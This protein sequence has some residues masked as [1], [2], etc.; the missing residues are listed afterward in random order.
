V[1]EWE[2]KHTRVRAG[3]PAMRL[4][5]ARGAARAARR[6]RL[7]RTGAAPPPAAAP[8]LLHARSRVPLRRA[9]P[10]HSVRAA[11]G[12]A[13]ACRAMESGSAALSRSWSNVPEA[14]AGLAGRA[15][16]R[17]SFARTCPARHAGAP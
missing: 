15:C 14:N 1:L 6:V 5:A 11:G 10:A 4:P 9:A 12:G 8:R 3:R 7:A 13:C 16:A 17:K 2:A